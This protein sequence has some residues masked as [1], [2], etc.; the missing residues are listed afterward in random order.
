MGWLVVAHR[1]EDV[2]VRIAYALSV[3]NPDQVHVP[4]RVGVKT[5]R[6]ATDVD[7]Q[8]QFLVSQEQVRRAVGV[9][10][11][12]TFFAR[13]NPERDGRIPVADP[14]TVVLEQNLREKLVG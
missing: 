12:A 10:R 5:M 7:R 8:T 2:G 14:G 9:Q 4:V 1:I 6:D 11:C 3:M 13:Q